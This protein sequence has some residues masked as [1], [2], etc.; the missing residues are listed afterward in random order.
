MKNVIYV[1]CGCIS[2]GLLC[3]QVYERFDYLT[4][5]KK[6]LAPSIPDTLGTPI[7][8]SS[9]DLVAE[10]AKNK[11]GNYIG[12]T[13]RLEADVVRRTDPDTFEMTTMGP[14]IF[15]K[16]NSKDAPE[17]DAL[18]PGDRVIVTGRAEDYFSNR[19]FLKVCRFGPRST[20][21]SD[22]WEIIKVKP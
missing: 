12:Q 10:S 15:C 16:Y 9:T 7:I 5:P 14:T 20:A 8:L 4:R 11:L 2:L 1:I 22:G 19:L 18:K 3:F 17:G 13:V 21:L 6:S